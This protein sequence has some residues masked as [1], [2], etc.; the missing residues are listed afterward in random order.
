[1]LIDRKLLTSIL[2]SSV[3]NAALFLCT[4]RLFAFDYTN[5]ELGFKATLPDGLDDFSTNMRVKAL[6]SRGKVS[7]AGLTKM[8]AIQ[9]LGGVIGRED[10][11]KMPARPRN[12]TLEKTSWKGFEI[13]VFRIVENI[14]GTSF[15]TFNAQVP[16]RPRAI[17]VSVV[18]PASDDSAVRKE[19]QTIVTSVEGPTNWLT[20]EE[21]SA[22]IQQNYL[23]IIIGLF[24]L[25]VGKLRI[26][27]HYGLSGTGARVAGFLIFAAGLVLPK[28]TAPV[29]IFAR[30]RGADVGAL[31][32]AWILFNCAVIWGIIALL[33]LQ[34]GNAY[35][36]N[37]AVSM[38]PP[39]IPTPV[40]ASGVVLPASCPMCQSP[41]PPEQPGTAKTCPTCGADL[42]RRRG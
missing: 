14:N 17:Q 21:R 26:T 1:M 3:W 35:A 32:I 40:T 9:D 12:A 2:K 39:I 27:R 6:V 23:A 20:A 31:L 8:I 25:I 16:L 13:D 22:R 30:S 19:M 36:K 11:S 33:I 18:G 37:S 28:L 4:I 24:A 7:P 34:Y 5:S 38:P 41:I 10:L 15:V 29:L 42:T